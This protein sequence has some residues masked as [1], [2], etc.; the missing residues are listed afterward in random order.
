[1]SVDKLQF[2]V[3]LARRDF[4]LNVAA[5]WPLDGCTAVFGPSGS[6]K[7]TLLRLLAGFERPDT[8]HIQCASTTWCDTANGVW[9]APHRRGVGLVF[10]D[11]ALFE[12]LTVADNLTFAIDRA[13]SN[14]RQYGLDEVV[15]ACEIGGLLARRPSTLSGGE[16]QRVAVARTLLSYPR[17]VLLDEPLTALDQTRRR[18]L[19]TLLQRLPRDFG[20]PTVLVSH[21]IDEVAE[22][23]DYT[24]LLKDG[25]VAGF[26]PTTEVL[27]ARGH[28]VGFTLIDATVER[29]DHELSVAIV[30]AFGIAFTLPIDREAPPIG[31][32]RLRIH[33][34]DVAIARRAPEALSIRNKVNCDLVAISPGSSA[35]L[36][37]LE[38]AA[39]G[40]RFGASITRAA[41]KELQ[42]AAGQTVVA[43]IKSAS[44]EP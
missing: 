4:A 13:P 9:L 29:I 8:G 16:R 28:D 42:L 15:V 19:A 23:A 5:T 1:M 31:K 40:Q 18:R 3:A 14:G 37:R 35:A 17:L 6:G 41:V 7:T 26:G 20:V 22:L 2:D 10:Q 39:D 12:H 21:G 38:L 44:I 24:L 11:I 25:E 33:D 27:N 32:H 43:L 34:R 30:T 36:V